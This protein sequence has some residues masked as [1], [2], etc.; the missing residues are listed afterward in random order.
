MLLQRKREALEVIYL[1]TCSS[2]AVLLRSYFAFKPLIK[3]ES[4]STSSSLLK[5][6]VTPVIFMMNFKRISSFEVASFVTQYFVQCKV[7]ALEQTSRGSLCSDRKTPGIKSSIF[8]FFVPAE[9]CSPFSTHTTFY[10]KPVINYFL[11][12]FLVNC[13]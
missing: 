2:S 1:A 11:M 8:A 10:V 6:S 13:A 3:I 4:V 5:K 12:C 9:D 7:D